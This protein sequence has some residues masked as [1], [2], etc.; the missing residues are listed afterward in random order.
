[1]KIIADLHTHTTFSH[2]KG[3]VLDNV[4]A[5][6]SRGLRA[7][8]IADHGP[9]SAPW[10]GA[11]LRDL[12][13][14]LDEVRELDRR[15]IGIK[16]LASAECNITST[17]GHLDVPA[18]LRGEMDIV[19]AGLHPGIL[20]RSGR[21]WLAL[22]GGNWY[23]KMN[24]GYRSRARI[25]NTRAVVE[26]VLRNDI[27]VITHP[28]YHLDIDTTELARACAFRNT[29]MEINARH[30]EMT[31]EFCRLAAR[32]GAK[33]VINS[34]A[35]RPGDVGNLARGIAV[36][37]AAGLGPEH[38]L[39]ADGGGLFEWLKQ[40]RGRAIWTDWAEQPPLDRIGR[41]KGR[42]AANQPSYWADWSNQG[43][44]H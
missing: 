13:R 23:A 28:G 34:D 5:A 17:R 41:E 7:I 19:L 44:I 31:V 39:N 3:S 26:A 25:A 9:R 35:H 24:P 37:R 4:T 12:K 43:K 6:M 30:H 21:D 22:T 10:V 16:V 32:V 42:S 27:D 1:M 40:K 38:V 20:P 15:A 29:A 14:M 18:E 36:A 2:G 8:G 33:F 11:S